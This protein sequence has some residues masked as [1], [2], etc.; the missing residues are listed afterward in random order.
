MPQSQCP[1]CLLEAAA[2]HCCPGLW[3]LCACEMGE[4]P[5][6]LILL[7][8]FPSFFVEKKFHEVQSLCLNSG[9]VVG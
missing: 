8:A 1:P 3:K 9:H 2:L 5:W 4:K 6:L 7:I